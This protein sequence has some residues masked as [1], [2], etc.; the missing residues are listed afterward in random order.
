MRRVDLHCYPGTDVWIAS[1][2]P[3]VE[4]LGKYW[5]KTWAAKSEDEVVA[6]VTAA[7]IEAVLVAFDIESVTGAPPCGNAYVAGLRDRH[8]N[9]FLQ[10]WGAGR[11]AQGRG[12]DHR[13]D[14]RG[15]GPPR[16]RLPLPPDHG[17]LRGR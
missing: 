11:S 2:G 10:A 17:P 4:A 5:G 6:D 12:G 13:G 14:Q 7:G 9:A 16:P 1:Q 15:A 3:Y 8:P